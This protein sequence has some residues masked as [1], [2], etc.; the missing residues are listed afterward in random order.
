MNLLIKV[1]TA[2]R[3]HIS[4]QRQ[5]L[6]ASKSLVRRATCPVCFGKLHATGPANAECRFCGAEFEATPP[7]DYESASYTTSVMRS[8]LRKGFTAGARDL[9]SSPESFERYL[10]GGIAALLGQAF[11]YRTPLPTNRPTSNFEREA[12]VLWTEIQRG[13]CAE[14]A[15]FKATVPPDDVVNVLR[16]RSPLVSSSSEDRTRTLMNR[17]C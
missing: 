12:Q 9:N 17:G 7:V 13:S 11:V 16:M 2:L 3:C 1:L 8:F 14:M 10:R 6:T 5:P 4:R 15:D